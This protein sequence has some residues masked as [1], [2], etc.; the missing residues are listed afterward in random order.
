MINQENIEYYSPIEE[1]INIYSHALCFT[2]SII[3]TVLLVIHAASIGN[4]WYTVSVSIFGA[5]LIILFASSTLYHSAKKT[6]TE[7]FA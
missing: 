6:G 3:A 4:I 1:K 2:A 7:K 5:S